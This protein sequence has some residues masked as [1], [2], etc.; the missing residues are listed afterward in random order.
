MKGKGPPPHTIHWHGI[1]P[2]PLND[3]VGHCSAEFGSNIYQWQPNFIGSYFYH[4]HRN[5][6]QHFEFGLFGFLPI[7]PPDAYFASV[8]GSDF[9]T[10]FIP[11]PVVLNSIPIGACS[12]GKFRTAANLADYNRSVLVGKRFNFQAG[13]PVFG[14]AGANG[15]G[16]GDPH[17]FT[18]AYDVEAIWVCDDRDSTWSD[19]AA[20]DEL[21]NPAFDAAFSTFPEHGNTPGDDDSFHNNVGPSGFFAFN[22][23][24]ADYWY[25]TGV[26]VPAH[27]GDTA[28]I[29]PNVTLPAALNSGKSGTQVSISALRNQT[30]LVR[31]LCA[32]YNKIRVTFPMDVVIIAWDGRA[33]GVPPFG[34]Y[35]HAYVVPAGTP[36]VTSTAR[37][38]D[39]LIKATQAGSFRAKCEFLDTRGGNVLVTVN[40][41]II[42]T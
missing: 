7:E 40:M 13:D 17:A 12:D 20:A 42:V 1:E 28:A 33:L 9:T 18:V 19:I 39:A 37:R 21:A 38:Y 2:T 10:Q 36:V 4:C 6:M 8:E 35:N 15:V 26:P 11:N 30:I 16:V 34:L 29:P 3:G 32:A 31:C 24:N 14:V 22:D 41:P 23:F 27:R 5:T 25:I